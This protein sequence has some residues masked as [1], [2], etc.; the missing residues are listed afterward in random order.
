MQPK[1]ALRALEPA[2]RPLLQRIYERKRGP[3]IKRAIE[4]S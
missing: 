3:M 1:G 4:S 2:L